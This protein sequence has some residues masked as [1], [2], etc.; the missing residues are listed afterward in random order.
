MSIYRDKI[1]EISRYSLFMSLSYLLGLF[2]RI[3]FPYRTEYISYYRYAFLMMPVHGLFLWVLLWF[4]IRNVPQSNIK[5]RLLLAWSGSI[6]ASV[7]H[8]IVITIFKQMPRTYYL[9][10]TAIQI[11]I[12][13]VI[14]IS[15]YVLYK[16]S[17]QKVQVARRTCLIVATFIC[18][19]VITK[20]VIYDVQAFS[21]YKKNE[22]TIKNL[23]EAQKEIDDSLM[24]ELE[25]GMYTIDNPL[26]VLDPYSRSPLSALI[27]FDTEEPSLISININGE[28]YCLTGQDYAKRHAVPIYG[29]YPDYDNRVLIS[30]ENES[31]EMKK[32]E[33]T[34][35]TEKLPYSLEMT[36]YMVTENNEDLY[37]PG[38]NFLVTGL[39][40]ETQRR[41]IDRDGNIRW[42]MRDIFKM[43]FP[44]CF[45]KYSNTFRATGMGS[46]VEFD[47]LGKIKSVCILPKDVWLHHDAY[48]TGSNSVVLLESEGKK[49]DMDRIE[50][51]DLLSGE[52]VGIIDYKEILMPKRNESIRFYDYDWM[53]MNSLVEYEKD[54]IISSNHQSLVMRHD[55]DG[56]IKWMLT[57]P[58]GWTEDYLPYILTPIGE[59]FEYCYNQHAV[60]VISGTDGNTDT[61]DIILFDNGTGRNYIEKT[62]DKPLYS[63]MV[64]YRI[65][66]KNMTVE[67]LWQWGKEYPE[68]FSAWRGDADL[69]ENGNILGTFNKSADDGEGVFDRYIDTTYVEADKDGNII[70][71]CDASAKNEGDSYT[72]YRCERIS[73]YNEYTRYPDL[74]GEVPVLKIERKKEVNL[75]LRKLGLAVAGLA[76]CLIFTAC[77]VKDKRVSGKADIDGV[78][79]LEVL[80]IAYEEG[81]HTTTQIKQYDGSMKDVDYNNS[82]SSGN[83]YCLIKIGVTKTAKG[84]KAFEWERLHVLG[85]DGESYGRIEDIFLK[86]HG[87]DRLPKTNLQI[88][89]HNGWISYEL[90]QGVKAEKIVYETDDSV[91]TIKP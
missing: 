37:Q 41:A 29:L 66:E 44:Y 69:L 49:T 70:W 53:H 58:D 5:K 33:E 25:T 56:N 64:I 20:V 26:V 62:P 38:F 51:V 16:K 73:M 77:S 3:G 35:K 13:T 88:G 36:K 12:I 83:M 2:L 54:F 31:G 45:N 90:P 55:R 30:A 28:M 21:D 48:L 81:L 39:N 79:T 87:Y 78:W 85:D 8:C 80:G 14:I 4:L 89:N 71:R 72:D 22:K 91:I 76:L 42:Y 52:S 50:E 10:G 23:V 82:P 59:D 24:A 86:D 60:E 40:S 61:V 68:L 34:I 27:L 32:R 63:R 15:E 74:D 75:N 1:R 47:F 17:L 19:V 57:R 43:D 6:I 46:F 67:Q 65:D 18:F 7:L 84:G 11:A 9:F